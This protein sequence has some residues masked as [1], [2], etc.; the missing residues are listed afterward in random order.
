LP[1]RDEVVH[2]LEL[3]HV[4]GVHVERHVQLG[5]GVDAALLH[6]LDVLKNL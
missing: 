3:L 1:K 6:R 4:G 2:Q 5:G